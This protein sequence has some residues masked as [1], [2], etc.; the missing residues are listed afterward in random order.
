MI[1]PTGMFERTE[2]GDGGIVVVPRLPVIIG[3]NYLW[4]QT[5]LL[6]LS[7]RQ[8][9]LTLSNF[10]DDYILNEEMIQSAFP[11]LD[12]QVLGHPTFKEE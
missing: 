3:K 1:S 11:R 7:L 10:P 5:L 12:S 6:T 9:L 4:S 8:V 2:D